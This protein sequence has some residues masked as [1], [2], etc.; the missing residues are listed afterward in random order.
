MQARSELSD[1]RSAL[2]VE[3]SELN[4]ER[5][6][7]TV[8]G[9]TSP[10]TLNAQPSTLP[11]PGSPVPSAP[12]PPSPADPF[13]LS[14]RALLS[15]A[16]VSLLAGCN[17]LM[18]I[19]FFDRE[20]ARKKN[21]RGALRGESGHSKLIGDYIRIADSTLGY[22]KVQGVGLVDRL[23]GTG[24]DP[25]A[26]PYRKEILDEMRRREIKDPQT[27]LRSMDTA[28]VVVT[29]YIPPIIRKGEK[30]DVE[31]VLPDGSESKS[32]AGGWLMPCRLTEHALLGGQVREGSDL[33]IA[34]GPILIAALGEE[35]GRNSN[36]HR[37]GVIPAGATYIGKDRQ[38]TVGIRSEYRSVRMSTQI[39][40]RI[41]RRFHDYDK[42]GLQRPMAEAK[43]DAVLELIVHDRYRDNYPRYL[44]C[45]R[46]MPLR[47]TSVE[48]HMR[49]QELGD[50]IQFGPTSER[51]AL[52]LEAIG[53]DAIPIL[54]EGLE[55]PELEARFRAAE[56][57]AYLGNA[58][59]VPALQEAADKEPAF[60]IFAFAALAAL[61]D[62]SAAR[63]LTELMNHES[64]ETRYGAFRAYSTM[65]PSDPTVQGIEMEGHFSLHP[66]ESTGRPLVHLTRRKK[67]EIVLFGAN[68]RFR[69]PLF[70]RAG[71]R[72]LVQ[73]SA[74]G[75]RVTIKRIAA[76]EAAQEREV[77]AQVAE[78]IRV[79]SELGATYPEIVQ[80]LVQAEKQH[81][82]PGQIAIDALPKPGRLYERPPLQDSEESSG[83]S[84][85]VD[86]VQ[87]GGHSLSPNL[88]EE[89]P[90]ETPDIPTDF[91]DLPEDEEGNPTNLY[92]K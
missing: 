82:L 5:S 9:R 40:N 72:I 44:Q 46:H 69:M 29:A 26:S 33:A 14:R 31:I 41:G 68:Q 51:A 15:V 61:Q 86:S 83:G 27:F 6:E 20:D 90:G 56:A 48:K 70:L 47:A 91:T 67:A 18:K 65:A 10:S 63:A 36:G 54:K 39:A 78:V 43:S 17:R 53:V 79:C 2:R 4:V 35:E 3:C 12:L 21:V 28:L 34:T 89:H 11:S 59:G 16:A 81:N 73:G 19:P 30:M 64:I 1:P 52:E 49:L 84:Q 8:E 62:G 80:M 50:E 37:R 77:S 87:I 60:R 23:N 7:L 92:L 57:L 88:F 25:P 45:I 55:S 66:V 24:E 58:D 32:L 13:R 42:H 75:D 76:G 22:I 71:S 85:A 74:K 38:L